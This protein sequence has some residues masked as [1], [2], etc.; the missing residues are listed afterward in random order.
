ML[1]DLGITDDG[2]NK[3]E[4]IYKL[5]SRDFKKALIDTIHEFKTVC[6]SHYDVTLELDPLYKNLIWS[7]SDCVD[8]VWFLI[9]RGYLLFMMSRSYQ[10][11]R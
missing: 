6:L 10:S 9:E 7:H 5:V 3:K 1:D 4:F 2:A 11:D 8:S